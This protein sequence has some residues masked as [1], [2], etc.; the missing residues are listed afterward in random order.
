[1][2]IKKY[3]IRKTIGGLSIMTSMLLLL[4][5]VTQYNQIF[6]SAKYDIIKS[7]QYAK[8]ALQDHSKKPEKPTIF[9][10][11]DDGEIMKIARTD[12]GEVSYHYRAIYIPDLVNNYNDFP[13]LYLE[14]KKNNEKK[15]LETDIYK[16]N[17]A[18]GLVYFLLKLEKD[19]QTIFTNLYTGK[20]KVRLIK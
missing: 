18:K 5:G 6:S 8:T 1:M 10:L 16:I 7:S 14:T 2:K 20:Y 17:R 19:H 3:T 12:D 13:Q 9:D 11:N 4:I 15:W